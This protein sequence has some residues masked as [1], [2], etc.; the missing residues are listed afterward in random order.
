MPK[1]HSFQTIQLTV[2]NLEN[3]WP[4]FWIEIPLLVR[5]LTS[6]KC[7]WGVHKQRKNAAEMFLAQLIRTS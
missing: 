2:R 3:L 5:S 4:F 6:D 7:V 1:H